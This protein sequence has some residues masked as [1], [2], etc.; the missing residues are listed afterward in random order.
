MKRARHTSQSVSQSSDRASYISIS[1]SFEADF[2][3][4]GRV[5]IRVN[6]GA[7]SFN[8]PHLTSIRALLDIVLHESDTVF[9]SHSHYPP[10]SLWSTVITTGWL[11]QEF[12][13]DPFLYR[14]IFET[15]YFR[16]SLFTES[17]N[18]RY[19][20]H[21]RYTSS[22]VNYHGFWKPSQ[23]STIKPS[24]FLVCSVL[25]T[26]ENSRTTASFQQIF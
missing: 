26:R 1:L 6:L 4:C 25:F 17:R 14:R 18:D 13:T 7:G 20:R 5:L 10:R 8:S 11:L 19:L 22:L 24:E 15:R 9:F 3:V 16:Y 23:T 2:R 21:N 12:R